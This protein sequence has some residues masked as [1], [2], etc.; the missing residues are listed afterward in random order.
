MSV[1]VRET[2]LD[3]PVQRVWDF[4]AGPDA[5]A[6]LSPPGGE[7][8]IESFHPV[9]EGRQVVLSVRLAPLPLRVRW[10]A[11]YE[12]VDPPHRFVDVA[13]SSPFPRWEHHHLFIDVGGR[14]LA[15]DEVHYDVPLGAVGALLGGPFVEAAL[16]RQFDH[17]HRVLVSMFGAAPA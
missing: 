12:R 15:R 5:L 17:R 16:R 1:F 10:V 13:L 4:H 8:R 9:E 6:R 3:A 2:L 7:V 11:R 14:C